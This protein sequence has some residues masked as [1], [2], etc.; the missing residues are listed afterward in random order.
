[1]LCLLIAS[2]VWLNTGNVNQQVAN[3]ETQQMRTP[4][5]KADQ[6]ASSY[7]LSNT[8]R[9]AVE[10]ITPSVV[11]IRAITWIDRYNLGFN[12]PDYRI[13]ISLRQFFG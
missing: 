10:I 3:A 7:N 13:Y 6:R 5:D 2:T 9:T 12:L 11:N 1:M 8:F 4:T